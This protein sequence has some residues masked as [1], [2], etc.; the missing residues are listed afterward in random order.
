MRVRRTTLALVVA[1]PI[2]LLGAGGARAYV[3]SANWSGYAA[4]RA[5]LSFSEVSAAWTQPN[6]SCVPGQRTYAALWV[7]LG[8]YRHGIHA[9]E[10]VGSEV[11]CTATGRHH[12]RAWYELVPAPTRWVKLSVNGGDTVVASVTVRGHVADL[13]LADLTTRQSLHRTV[14]AA[15]VDTSSAE[16]IVE[17]PAGCVGRGNCRVLPLA[18]F[19][20]TTFTHA[21]ARSASGHVGTISDPSWFASRIMLRPHGQQFAVSGT[22]QAGIA[23]TSALQS[24][25]SSFRVT[26]SQLAVRAAVQV[27]RAVS[28]VH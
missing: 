11:D 16:W 7:G 8:G 4:H 9:L 20:S 26:F 25:G 6:V 24:G 23:T 1:A 15:R 19:G 13:A 14:R 28:I 22:G 17:A 3:R 12:S 18:N 5:G 10:Q 2:A 27:A 21:S